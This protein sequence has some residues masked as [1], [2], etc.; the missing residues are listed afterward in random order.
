MRITHLSRQ[1]LAD[2]KGATIVEFALVAP[3]FLI[4]LLGMFDFGFQVYAQS[5]LSGAMQTAARE[6]TLEPGGMT[7]DEIDELVENSVLLVVPSADPDFDRM[8]YEDFRD[9]DQPERFED[10]NG[11]GIC[12][13]GEPY[14]DV[15]F[16]DQYD[17]DR[18]VEGVGGAD[19]A[20]YYEARFTYNRK[21]PL[22]EMLGIDDEVVLYSA[23]VLRNQPY[24][25][26]GERNPDVRFC[27]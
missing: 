17:L 25:T 3:V 26:Q 15:N 6:S 5:V 16:N 14:E 19:D 4:M 9:V 7:A 20:V 10:T 23:T 13:D 22:W 2:E 11:D 12:N 18:G 27:D 8:N 1:V 21:F 24:D